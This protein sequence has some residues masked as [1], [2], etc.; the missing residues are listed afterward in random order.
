MSKKENA[1]MA[2]V[3]G[4]N[5]TEQQYSGTVGGQSIDFATIQSEIK[6][7]HMESDPLF[8]PDFKTNSFQGLTWRLG[9]DVLSPPLDPLQPPEE[10]M[11]HKATEN[12]PLTLET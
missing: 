9:Y 3:G 11:D 4:R 2:V 8:P 5:T 12:A 10:W 6:T 7:A 1:K